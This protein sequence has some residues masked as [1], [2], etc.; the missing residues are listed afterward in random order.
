MSDSIS[1]VLKMVKRNVG[2]LRDPA[3][4]FRPGP[5]NVLVLPDLIKKFGLVEGALVSGTVRKDKKGLKLVEISAIC[6]L[7]PEK[8]KDRTPFSYL[9]PVAPDERFKIE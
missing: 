8:F 9:T 3:K 5:D 4:S 6:G 7:A 1:G 2:V